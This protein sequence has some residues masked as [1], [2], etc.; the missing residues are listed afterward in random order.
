VN[1]FAQE[2]SQR[3]S[4]LYRDYIP[5]SQRYPTP[6][7]TTTQRAKTTESI[8]KLSFSQPQKQTP[9]AGF[10][11]L[12]DSRKDSSLY[13]ASVTQVKNDIPNNLKNFLAS[14]KSKPL[15]EIDSRR[16]VSPANANTYH[17]PQQQQFKQSKF[18]QKS[19][20][21]FYYMRKF[22]LIFLFN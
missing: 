14:S 22:K 19:P 3:I 7:T 1:H 12:Y 21:M 10:T 16:Y 5:Y 17:Q 6:A 11:P 18:K 9:P 20:E 8:K 4:Q 13:H 2:E 15:D